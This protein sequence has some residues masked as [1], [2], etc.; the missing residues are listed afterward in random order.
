MGTPS[1]GL[2]ISLMTVFTMCLRSSIFLNV[3][4]IH[5]EQL[6]EH[7]FLPVLS[8]IVIFLFLWTDYGSSVPAFFFFS[9]CALVDLSCCNKLL[10]T[11]QLKQQGFIFQSPRGWGVQGQGSCRSRSDEGRLPVWLCPP[12][13]RTE[14]EA[15]SPN[16]FHEG[17]DPMFRGGPASKRHH[18]GFGFSM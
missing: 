8:S 5:S 9:V 3:W 12:R 10:Q 7:L 13:R 17:T 2:F 11:E 4:N 18:W 6:L 14:R 1:L 16:S 15:H